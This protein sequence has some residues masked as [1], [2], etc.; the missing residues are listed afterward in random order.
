M[1]A[2]HG[3]TALTTGTTLNTIGITR[4]TIGKT[5]PTTGKIILTTGTATESSETTAVIQQ[6]IPFLNQMVEQTFM[7]L[8]ETERG[9]TNEIPT[10]TFT[11][12]YGFF[13]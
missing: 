5:T 2:Q 6:A 11:Y 7:T 1:L 3:K 10:H 9:T 8:T 13:F 4:P 12:S